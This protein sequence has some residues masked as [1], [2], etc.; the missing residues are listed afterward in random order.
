M[1]I[2]A[3]EAYNYYKGLYPPFIIF[4]LI[5]KTYTAYNQDAIQVSNALGIKCDSG[6]VSVPSDTI[7]DTISELSKHGLK[8]KTVMCRNDRGEYDLPD[9]RQLKAERDLDM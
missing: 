1:N 5:N 9:V 3:T 2:E 4:F 7:L 8:A 6:Q